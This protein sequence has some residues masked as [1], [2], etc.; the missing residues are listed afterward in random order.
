MCVGSVGLALL[1]VSTCVRYCEQDAAKRQSDR[2]CVPAHAAFS[3]D[4]SEPACVRTSLVRHSGM[5]LALAVG[6]GHRPSR[7]GQ[8]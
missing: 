6:Q 4:R 2:H 8:S 1:G 7:L 3:P 5:I